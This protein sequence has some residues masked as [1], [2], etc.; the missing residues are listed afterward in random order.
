MAE[1]GQYPSR[2]R[3]NLTPKPYN[4][5]GN[6]VKTAGRRVSALDRKSASTLQSSM[7]VFTAS[8]TS[9]INDVVP[10]MTRF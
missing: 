5:N 4:F 10:M 2:N 6:M 8:K 7:K 3:L 1:F 9:L